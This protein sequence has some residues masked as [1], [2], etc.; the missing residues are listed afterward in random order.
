MKNVKSNVEKESLNIGWWSV[1][2]FA[3]V[4]ILWLVNC[5]WFPCC[6]TAERRGQFGDKFGAVNALFSGLAFAGLIITLVMQYYELRLQ[7]KGIS[8]QAREMNNQRFEN[9]LFNMLSMQQNIIGG[10]SYEYNYNDGST[11]SLKGLELFQFFYNDIEINIGGQQ[12]CGVGSRENYADYKE[13]VKKSY[14]LASYFSH[15]YCIFK[16][17]DETHL[18]DEDAK[19]DYACIVRAQLSKY[20][21]LML[22]YNAI[23]DDDDKFKKLIEKYAIFNNLCVGEL[24]KKEHKN[25]YDES[26][27]E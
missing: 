23:N 18:I 2:A 7:R 25:L 26:A 20:E 6:S 17:I 13:I 14:F 19:Y 16:Y 15:L 1:V 24:A 3:C 8:D 11:K 9:S 12:S 27:Y 4:V 5:F 21:L 10:I 22:F